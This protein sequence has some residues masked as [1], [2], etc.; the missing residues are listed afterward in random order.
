MSF[1]TE[2]CLK[3]IGNQAYELTEPLLYND[4][5]VELTVHPLFDFD[6]ASVPKVLW[7]FGFSPM[8]G[9]YQRAAALHDAL[10]AGEV[11]ERS[12]CDTLFL[13]AMEADGVRYLKRYAMYYAVRAAGWTVWK[14]HNR[15][16][17]ELY[18]NFVSV[19]AFV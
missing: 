15:E 2:L 13:N 3:V 7:S 14:G 12:I 1:K 11:F 8:T 10:Y 5:F 16:E 6:G 18:R 17:V 4:G 9:G 19:V